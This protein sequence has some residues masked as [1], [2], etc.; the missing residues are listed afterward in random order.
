M[1]D[2]PLDAERA[3]Q[4][5]APDHEVTTF[6]EGSM[7]VERMATGRGPDV[8]VL[9]WLMPGLSGIEICQFLRASGG[10]HERVGILMLTAAGDTRQIVE[11]LS[12]GADDYLRKPYADE[13]LVARVRALMRTRQLLERSERAEAN[14]RALL[15]GAPD[16]LLAFD[17]QWKLVFANQEAAKV[18]DTSMAA[19]VGRR[20]QELIPE[21]VRPPADRSGEPIRLQDVVIGGRVYAPILNTQ[22]SS[23]DGPQRSRA[24]LILR[25]VTQRRHEEARRAEFY[26]MVVHDMRSPLMAMS[27]R[28]ALMERGQYGPAP[29]SMVA[30]LRKNT[31]TIQ[32]LV[33]LIT[34]F[35]DV[36]RFE[37]AGIQLDR[38]RVDLAE[39]S[40]TTLDELRPLADA[41]ALRLS[42]DLA[43]GPL[44]VLGDSGRLRQVLTNLLSNAI[45]FTPGGGAIHLGQQVLGAFVETSVKDT[46]PGIPASALPTLFDRY[47]RVEHG[48]RTPGTGLGLTIAKQIIE[49]HGGNIT[50]ETAEGQGSTFRFT[51]PKA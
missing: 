49:A 16:A 48:L 7:A 46:G 40:R 27:L 20:G 36:A 41:R 17:E 18:F 25:D 14:V 13:E 9:D 19:L 29:P 34:D 33:K 10:P 38:Q 35:L 37:E 28:N 44:P 31:A 5:L 23:V 24:T 30:E 1:D 43:S 32:S 6:L 50:V 42:E 22:Q 12:A 15:Q 47:T 45:K 8:L 4:A 51:L 21:L 39:L 3:R 2:S 26:S 11:G